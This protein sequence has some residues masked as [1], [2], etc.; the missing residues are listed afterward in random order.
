M[1]FAICLLD[2]MIDNE[3][4]DLQVIFVKV[5]DNPLVEFVPEGAHGSSGVNASFW[6]SV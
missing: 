5:L 2:D 3:M 6:V 1:K 4:V